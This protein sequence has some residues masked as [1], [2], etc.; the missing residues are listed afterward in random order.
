VE[1]D[2]LLI[3]NG[4]RPGL[5]A[6]WKV[7]DVDLELSEQQVDIYLVH[8]GSRICCSSCNDRGSRYDTLRFTPESKAVI[9]RWK[10]KHG[11]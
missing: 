9:P 3:P 10:W 6:C 4:H 2:G 1:M 7:A 11:F 5:D 8:T